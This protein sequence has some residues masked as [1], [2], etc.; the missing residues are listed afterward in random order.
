MDAKYQHPSIQLFI[1]SLKSPEGCGREIDENPEGCTQEIDETKIEKLEH[2]KDEDDDSRG[3][4]D[5]V[6]SHCGEKIKEDSIT[7]LQSEKLT[8]RFGSMAAQLLRDV[9]MT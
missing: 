5:E 9:K 7:S 1:M 3:G 6:S 4:I 2:R 8:R